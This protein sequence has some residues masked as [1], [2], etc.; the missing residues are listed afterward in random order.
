MIRIPAG[1]RR[2]VRPMAQAGRVAESWRELPLLNVPD[3]IGLQPVLVLA[4]HPDDETLGCGGLIA[5]CHSRGQSVHILVVTD[6]AASHPASRDYPAARLA[7][8]RANETKAAIATLGLPE[9]R[10]DFIGLPDGLAPLRGRRF[11][12]IVQRIVDYAR[13]RRIGTICT[14]WP[15]DPHRDHQATYRLGQAAARV[16]GARLF[17]YPVWGWTLP[18]DA[19][20]PAKPRY[21]GRL[22]IAPYVAAKQRAIACHRSQTTDMIHDAVDAF[23]LSSSFLANFSLP[24][25]V[26]L[27][28]QKDSGG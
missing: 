23:R 8:L 1:L 27:D 17:C 20:V 25:E 19:W 26:F 13:A 16:L 3:L 9:D 21:G 12:A 6:G 15:G 24:F 4:P 22:N 18:A 14:T 2:L 11:L 7:A 28:A 5:D 10:V